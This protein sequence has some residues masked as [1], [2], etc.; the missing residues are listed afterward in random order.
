M[1]GDESVMS[2]LT[3][4]AGGSLQ[5]VPSTVAGNLLRSGMGQARDVADQLTDL[6]VDYTPGITSDWSIVK[7]LE[8]VMTELPITGGVTRA[9]LNEIYAQFDSAVKH[10]TDD[11]TIDWGEDIVDLGV[12]IQRSAESKIQHYNDRTDQLYN[13]L[14]LSLIHI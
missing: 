8:Q 12:R 10:L 14:W 3:S 2:D 7:G 6:G 13:I 5:R 11:A 9:K 1:P 4:L